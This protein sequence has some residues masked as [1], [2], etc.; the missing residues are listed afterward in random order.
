[1]STPASKRTG[2]RIGI[3]ARPPANPHAEAWIRQGSADDLQKGDLY[4][5]R[6]TLDITPAMR[7]RIKVCLLYTSPS[8]RDRQKSRMPSSA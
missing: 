5:A 2:K 7:A 8:P 1:M 4:T 6:L 3:G